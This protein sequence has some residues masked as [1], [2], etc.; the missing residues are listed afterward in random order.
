VRI[1]YRCDSKNQHLIN[2][3]PLPHIA[4]LFFQPLNSPL[5]AIKHTETIRSNSPLT[6]IKHT[7]TIRSNSPLTAIKHTETI[8]SWS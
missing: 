8:R 1:N 2:G 7:E 6:A 5:T 4:W 3:Q